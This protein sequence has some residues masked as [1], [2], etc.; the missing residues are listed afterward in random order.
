MKENPALNSELRE[1][2]WEHP[3]FSAGQGREGSGSGASP[4]S[5]EEWKAAGARGRSAGSAAAAGAGGGCCP[6]GRG[7]RHGAAAAAAATGV[8]LRAGGP[9]EAEP[10]AVS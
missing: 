2:R 1:D 8:V 3:N 4:G 9:E 10:G 5:R 7:D 6:G